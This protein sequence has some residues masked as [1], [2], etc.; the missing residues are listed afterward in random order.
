M[1]NKTR[2]ILEIIVG[3]VIIFIGLNMLNSFLTTF[4]GG[5]IVVWNFGSLISIPTISG[6]QKVLKKYKKKQ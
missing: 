3:F 1:S 6:Y 4:I 5:L 2:S